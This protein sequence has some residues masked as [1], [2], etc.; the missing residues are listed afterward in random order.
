MEWFSITGGYCRRK[1][2]SEIRV[3]ILD[4]AV[5][6]SLRLIALFFSY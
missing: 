2:K 5:T 1:W 3:Q 4:K 6:I